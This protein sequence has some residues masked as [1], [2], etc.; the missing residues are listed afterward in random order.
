MA[1]LAVMAVAV[2][3]ACSSPSAGQPVTPSSYYLAL[4]DSLS[5][6]VQPATPPL[7]PRVPLGQSV[8]TDQGYADDLYAEL[9]SS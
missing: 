8:E 7:P 1:A 9:T 3:T 4:G 6:G 5:Q 2:L